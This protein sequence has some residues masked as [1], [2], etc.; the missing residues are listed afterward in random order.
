MKLN[1]YFESCSIALKE[2]SKE[3][4]GPLIDLYSS[5]V[6]VGSYDVIIMGVPDGRLSFGNE[7]CSL[8]P[9]EIRKELYDLYAGDWALSI[10]DL[11]NLKI[12]A[13]IEDTYHAI[14]D[15]SH[16]FSQ[17]NIP[18]LIL[19]GGH[20]LITPLFEAYSKFGK[21]LSFAS[22]DAYLD[23]QSQ[24]SYHS[25]SFLT[26]L[27]SSPDSLL[28]KYTLFAY[29][30]YLCSPSEVSLLKKMDFNLIRLGAF[31]ENY[32]EIEPY[33]RDLDHLSVD[34]CVMRTSEAPA[35][36]YTSPN[37]INAEA[38]CTLL[39]YTGMSLGV[40]SVL[41]SELNP[42]LDQ[43]NQSAKVYAQ[44]IWYFLEG[45]HLRFDDFPDINSDNFKKFHVNSAF[46]DLIF[47]KSNLTGRWWVELLSLPNDSEISLLPCSVN[48]YN[49][50]LE[51][52]IT[53]RLLT[54]FKF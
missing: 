15:V 53:T 46:S 1:D 27:L 32:S 52:Q 51:G 41:F 35:S 45:L 19:G 12:G 50:A 48:D 23:L 29:Q 31:T 42:T 24:D 40:K 38:L 5:Q 17:K 20:D 7:N 8:A 49:K 47:Y 22:A 54:Y 9:N 10:L 6:D 28:S 16:F 39:R 18:L 2:P 37:G 30:T 14:E 44:S 26:K 11:G 33:V 34:L 13:T 36:R 43:K 21:P 25:R 4:L 3:K